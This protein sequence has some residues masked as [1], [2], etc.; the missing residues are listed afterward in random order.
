MITTGVKKFIIATATGAEAAFGNMIAKDEMKVLNKNLSTF[1]FVIY[2]ASIIMFTS[3]ALLIIP[4][5]SIYTKGITDINYFR[6][7]FG[8]LIAIAEFFFCIRIP[9]QAITR[10]AGHYS[11]TRN[12]A[13]FETILNIVV[14][15]ILV[16]PF[17][18]N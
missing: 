3:M 4:F 17:L 5:I 14:S 9:Y 7:T 18:T 13:I 8:Y 2:S 11:Q 10:A 6:P 1:E 16:K 15:L 12:G